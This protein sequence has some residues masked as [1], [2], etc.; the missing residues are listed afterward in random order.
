MEFPSTVTTSRLGAA[1]P[2][3]NAPVSPT[4][5]NWPRGLWYVFS[6]PVTVSL[7][8]R[9]NS[10]D[11]SA[12]KK[13][14]Y[15]PIDRAGVEDLDDELDIGLGEEPEVTRVGGDGFGLTV[16][17][18]A[19]GV[20]PGHLDLEAGVV[21][22]EGGRRRGARGGR[23]GRRRKARDPRPGRG[24]GAWWSPSVTS[25]ARRLAGGIT[26]KEPAGRGERHLGG[27]PAALDPAGAQRR[28]ELLRAR[29]SCR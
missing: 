12:P 21:Q 1:T 11:V 25:R 23:Q 29:T 9:S 15:L 14:Q 20:P 27:S 26:G 4:L 16:A 13:T 5:A 19:A 7:T 17:G 6:A 3:S 24:F 10:T 2:G 8:V 18:A 28:D 22:A